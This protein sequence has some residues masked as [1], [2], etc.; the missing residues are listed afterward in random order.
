VTFGK[1]REIAA[2]V[3]QHR[4]NQSEYAEKLLESEL[5]VARLSDPDRALA[6][7]LTLGVVRWQ[8]TLD[9]LIS[10]RTDDRP[11]QGAV[12]NALRLGLYQLF[13]LDRIPAHAAVNETVEVARQMGCGPQSGFI[14]A[15]LRGC[16]RERGPIQ[17]QLAE[18]RQ[19]APHLGWSHPEWLVERWQRTFGPERL[20]RLLEWNNTPPRTFAR[21]NTLV[22]DPGK[23][24]ER[25]REENV[26]YDL[27]RWEWIP[28][29]LVFELKQHPPLPALGSFRDGW[30]YVQDPST[31]L[32]GSE[33]GARPGET[34]LDLCAA[35][36]GKTT[37]IAQVMNHQGRIVANDDSPARLKLVTENCQRLKVTGVETVS[38]V[39]A[40]EK[41]APFDR[42][43]VDAPCSNSGVLRRRVDAR[44]RMRPE[45]M[46]RLQNA[47]R[48]LLDQAAR[49]LKPGGTLVYST[50]SLEPEENAQR[51]EA[52]LGGQPQFELVRQR[53]L[54][55]MDDR[56]DGA[57]VATLRRREGA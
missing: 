51:V 53:Q 8:M 17:R 42:I 40:M 11:Q 55:P 34:I 15:I 35:P 26:S 29:N 23:L 16:Q 21:C 4:L 36:G 54:T 18:L 46:T 48:N 45:E 2:R 28:E 49:W 56:V 22:T 57:F 25:W 9:W 24:I 13:W 7:E 50:C 32:A 3:L 6:R 27:P 44:W 10:L 12:Q 52:F 1:P 41:R 31:L 20:Q 43:L 19:T 5:A 39:D 30:F 38:G 14:N 33:L 37:F 47:Q